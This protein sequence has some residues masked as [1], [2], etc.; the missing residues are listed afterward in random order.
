MDAAATTPTLHRSAAAA[1]WTDAAILQWLH[2]H[3][4]E[5]LIWTYFVSVTVFK[6]WY[7]ATAIVLFITAVGAIWGALRLRGAIVA[8]VPFAIFHLYPYCGMLWSA[9]PGAV[10][11]TTSIQL[12]FLFVVF[13]FWSLVRNHPL[14]AIVD[15]FMRTPFVAALI[16]VHQLIT[17]PEAPRSGGY[18]LPFMVLIVPFCYDR[19][20]RRQRP[21]YAG[22][23]LA[24]TL[25]V[26]IV[27]RSRAPMAAAALALVLAF[28]FLGY[29]MRARLRV[30]L[31]AL[32][33]G[34]LLLAVLLSIGVTREMTLR[35]WVRLTGESV[36][37]EDTYIA[38]DTS[39]LARKDLDILIPEM[40]LSAQ[41]LGVG[42]GAYRYYHERR[43]GYVLNVHNIYELWLVEGGL[44]LVAIVTWI[45]AMHFSTIWK[46]RR[47]PAR[48]FAI[49]IGISTVTALA[50]GVFHRVDFSY[51]VALGL[52]A[53][54][55]HLYVR[56]R[57]RPRVPA[58][59]PLTQS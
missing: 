56:R 10:L 54:M 30:L 13:L 42:L 26:L 33:A 19:L 35:M 34:P 4:C 52:V 14:D 24:L 31:I 40:M 17:M 27:S 36:V 39:E 43:F 2:L 9:Y 18:S 50:M 6:R 51:Y 45:L 8:M 15:M 53:G 44:V 21:W 23:C 7:I 48:N 58:R 20:V 59:I 57:P 37:H 38:A 29:S 28:V 41:P 55:R 5:A 47:T 49:A 3:G 11:Y 32:V 16:T 1:R 46:A 25:C 22:I 12:I